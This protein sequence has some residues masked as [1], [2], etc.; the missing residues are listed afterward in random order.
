[1]NVGNRVVRP[2]SR[3]SHE[4]YAPTSYGTT[5]HS[6]FRGETTDHEEEDL[7]EVP[8]TNL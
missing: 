1:M 4:K 2:S 3:T 8:Q 6:P 5:W 7:L